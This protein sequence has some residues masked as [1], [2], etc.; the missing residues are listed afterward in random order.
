MNRMVAHCEWLKASNGLPQQLESWRHLHHHCNN[1]DVVT[2]LGHKT[3]GY[4]ELWQ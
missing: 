2:S 3:H 1:Y 4:T